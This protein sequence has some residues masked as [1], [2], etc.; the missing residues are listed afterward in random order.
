VWLRGE[1]GAAQASLLGA[2]A[3]RAFAEEILL[4]KESPQA[5]Y[6]LNWL[7][8]EVDWESVTSALLEE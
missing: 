1:E 6:L 5:S 4:P 8:D 7:L 2:G 3:L